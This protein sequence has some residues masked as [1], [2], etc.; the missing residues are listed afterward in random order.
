MSLSDSSRRPGST[1]CHKS[2]TFSVH[3]TRWKRYRAE[4][5]FERRVH[6]ALLAPLLGQHRREVLR[7]CG[8]SDARST[9]D[10]RG[11][12]RLSTTARR[13]RLRGRTRERVINAA[14]T[15]G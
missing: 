11:R 1:L 13:P 3:R 15:R 5:G 14:E 10:G 8:Y 9:R 12:D 7:E 4:E 6:S 2:L